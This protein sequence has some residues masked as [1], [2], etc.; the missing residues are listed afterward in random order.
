VDRLDQQ[1]SV[2]GAENKQLQQQIT[3]K[4]L[5]I[6]NIKEGSQLQLKISL[7]Q[8]ESK[9]LSELNEQKETINRLKNKV[10]QEESRVCRLMEANLLNDKIKGSCMSKLKT[11]LEIKQENPE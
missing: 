10:L 6:K 8:L 9:F 1:T 11:L 7:S 4:N 5:E 2:L 3:Q